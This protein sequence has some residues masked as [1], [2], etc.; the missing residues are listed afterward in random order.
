M[1]G[2]GLQEAVKIKMK[3]KNDLTHSARGMYKNRMMEKAK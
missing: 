1:E 2:T 3:N